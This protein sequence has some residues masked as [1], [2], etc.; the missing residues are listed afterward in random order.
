MRARE[1]GRVRARLAMSLDERLERTKIDRAQSLPLAED[2]IV[3]AIFHE[4]AY[5]EVDRALVGR[6][7]AR[8]SFERERVHR[9]SGGG[10]P[11]HRLV[12]DDEPRIGV[13]FGERLAREIEIASQVRERRLLVVVRKQRVRERL[14]RD[15]DSLP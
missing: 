3:V 5:V 13:S 2:P 6:R 10:V 14:A 11:A 7:I 12:V 9:R 1:R 15:G 4:I 8:E